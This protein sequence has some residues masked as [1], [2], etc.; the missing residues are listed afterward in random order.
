M[1]LNILKDIHKEVEGKQQLYYNKGSVTENVS[2][3]QSITNKSKFVNSNSSSNG[4]RQNKTVLKFQK[5]ENN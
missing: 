2:K 3:V 4:M 5:V 1:S